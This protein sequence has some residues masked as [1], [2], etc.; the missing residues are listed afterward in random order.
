M[1]F[2]PWSRKARQRPDLGLYGE[3]LASSAANVSP[4]TDFQAAT[5]FGWERDHLKN[6]LRLCFGNRLWSVF[7][8]ALQP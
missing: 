1:I 2:F 7:G 5:H 6:E 3:A 8:N 4:E